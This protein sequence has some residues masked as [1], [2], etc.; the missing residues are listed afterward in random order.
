MSRLIDADRLVSTLKGICALADIL[1]GFREKPTIS[2]DDVIRTIE[3]SPTIEPEW[4][5]T[6]YCDPFE[7]PIFVYIQVEDMVVKIKAD[8]LKKALD[9]AVTE[10]KESKISV[11]KINGTERNNNGTKQP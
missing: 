7:N 3:K 2:F 6:H 4:K 5:P 9:M 1:N 8:D 11:V 10:G